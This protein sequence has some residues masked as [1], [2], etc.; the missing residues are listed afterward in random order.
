VESEKVF[1]LF[2]VPTTFLEKHPGQQKIRLRD[3]EVKTVDLKKVFS[4]SGGERPGE[5]RILTVKENEE[6]KGL[7]VDEV[8]NKS[9]TL[10]EKRGGM[11]E[12]FSGVIHSTYQDQS[13]EVPVLDLKKL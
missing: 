4:I 3:L 7:L 8:L 6:Y 10:L 9:S 11:G 12:Y 2:R 5:T 13:V 1:K